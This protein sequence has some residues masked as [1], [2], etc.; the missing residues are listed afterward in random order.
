MF[1]QFD[2][3]NAQ[4]TSH[5]KDLLKYVIANSS[6]YPRGKL[7]Y[8][9]I[10]EVK[11]D[12]LKEFDVDDNCMLICVVDSG[13]VRIQETTVKARDTLTL[14][15]PLHVTMSSDEDSSVYVILWE[16]ECQ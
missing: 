6:V 13:T 16:V 11:Q 8:M 15:G 2:T 14:T 10:I 9:Q 3:L 12:A 5:D 7:M 1:V 4:P